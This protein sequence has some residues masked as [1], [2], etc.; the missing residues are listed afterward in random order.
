VYADSSGLA[1]DSFEL[2]IQL[3]T[4]AGVAATPGL[5]FGSNAPQHHMRFAYTIDRKRIAEGLVRMAAFL[6]SR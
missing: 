2:A 4:E 5:D 6:D 3:L 1:A